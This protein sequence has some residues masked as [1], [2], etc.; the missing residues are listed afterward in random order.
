MR[1]GP[2]EAKSKIRQFFRIVPRAK[3]FIISD[4]IGVG[5]F[6]VELAVIS[7]EPFAITEKSWDEVTA[8][9]LIILIPTSSGPMRMTLKGF[10][11]SIL[12]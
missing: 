5:H 2:A 7:Q 11:V 3:K 4:R 1:A 8:H 9:P 6:P 12:N 10:L